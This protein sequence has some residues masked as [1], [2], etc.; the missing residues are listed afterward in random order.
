MLKE[1]DCAHRDRSIM[2]K[3]SF[4]VLSVSSFRETCPCRPWLGVPEKNKIEKTQA[5]FAAQT[6]PLEVT[7]QGYA[8]RALLIYDGI[9]Y[10]ILARQPFEGAPPALDITLFD[11]KDEEAVAQAHSVVS[12]RTPSQA[13]VPQPMGRHYGAHTQTNLILIIGCYY[14]CVA[15]PVFLQVE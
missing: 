15:F 3:V 1:T 2:H 13:A 14:I 11:V 9:H 5:F 8:K 4:I 10:D 7:T 12:P 6:V